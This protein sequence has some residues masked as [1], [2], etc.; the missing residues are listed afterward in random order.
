MNRVSPMP[1]Q[2]QQQQQQR[3]ARAGAAADGALSMP[4]SM[5]P[6]HSET[7]AGPHPTA[8]SSLSQTQRIA[9]NDEATGGSGLAA[10]FAKKVANNTSVY[11][12]VGL[13]GHVLAILLT[14]I[15]VFSGYNILP[16]QLPTTLPVTSDP[17]L[18]ARDSYYDS[19]QATPDNNMI[20]QRLVSMP[21][22]VISLFPTGVV[23]ESGTNVLT[24][25]NLF[26]IKELEDRLMSK[27]EFTTKLCQLKETS[28]T[29]ACVKPDSVL[30]LFGGT[31]AYLGVND[32]L[33][34]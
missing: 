6:L 22:R 18:A 31:Y 30:R 7:G 23:Y 11:Y 8:P 3:D 25:D 13:A 27:E 21:E 29:Y 19:A 24:K 4:M 9:E 33:G 14:V 10:S 15:L 32:T 2:Q 1:E 28:G 16:L 26:S 5:P 20:K 34:E 17:S 12:T